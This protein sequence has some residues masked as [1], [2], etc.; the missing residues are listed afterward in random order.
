MHDPTD[1]R[2]LT[3]VNRPGYPDAHVRPRHQHRPVLPPLDLTSGQR[4]PAPPSPA[5][6]PHK[7]LAGFP[8]NGATM[9]DPTFKSDFLRTL[10][11]RGYIHQI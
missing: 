11:A 2:R 3:P 8:A 6:N 4:T 5:R 1:T 9:S 7:T 10:Q